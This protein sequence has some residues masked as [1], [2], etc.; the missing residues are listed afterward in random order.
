MTAQHDPFHTR[1]QVPVVGGRLTVAVAGAPACSADRVILLVHGITA[2]HMAWRPVARRLSAAGGT[3]VLAPD[4]RGRGASARLPGPYGSASHVADL[5]AVL[6]QLNLPPVHLA[7][8]SMG[9]FVAARL[10]GEHPERVSGLL[11]IDGG[12]SIPV[13]PDA[14]PDELLTKTLGPAL[15]RLGQVFETPEDYLSLWRL[16]P[17]FVTAWNEDVEAYAGY[18]L[19][20][21]PDPGRPGAVRSVVSAEAVWTDGRE[22]LLDAPIRTAAARVRVPMRLLR[23]PRGLLGDDRPLIPQQVLHDFLTAHPAVRAETV[24]ETNHY[25]ILLGESPGPAYVARALRQ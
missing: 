14:E 22:L 3:C 24:R 6:D 5:V 17:A 15:D 2:S 8:H 1:F 19:E 9:A 23:A 4:L 25:T 7:G 20:Q 12:L 11:L 10:A 21:A 13:P 16:H 18:D